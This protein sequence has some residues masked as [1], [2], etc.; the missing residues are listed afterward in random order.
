MEEIDF[1][2]KFVVGNSKKLQKKIG[3]GRKILVE[4]SNV[5]TLLNLE[6]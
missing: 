2:V 5:F 1:C 3:F 6:N 4:P